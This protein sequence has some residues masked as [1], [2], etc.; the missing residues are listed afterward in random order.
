MFK[1]TLFLFIFGIFFCSFTSSIQ[2]QPKTFDDY[3]KG[4]ASYNLGNYEEALKNFN[5]AIND[6]PDSWASYQQAGYCYFHLNRRKKM[7]ASFNESLK[8]HPDNPELKAFIAG[9]PQTQDLGT[10]PVSS[11]PPPVRHLK[12][13]SSPSIADKVSNEKWGSSSWLNLSGALSYEALGDLSNA[14]NIWNQDITK[15]SAQGNASLANW[16]FQFGVEGGLAL[17]KTNVLSLQSGFET[18]HGFQENLV[19][20]SP[21][22]ENINPQLF[23]AGLNYYR[24]FPSENGRYFVTAGILFGEAIADYY[25]DDPVETLQGPLAGNNFG[26]TIGA[27]REWKMSPTVGFE[28]IGR[29]RY[30]TINQ[31]QN[32]YFVSTGG[33]GQAVLATDSLGNIGLASP[34]SIGQNGLRY[35]TLD[36]TGFNLGF[37]FNFY[38]F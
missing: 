6:D 14:A 33:T 28:L 13:T 34:Q 35:A 7:T 20:S 21:V 36:F 37:A 9:L 25:Q 11:P 38:L 8:L 18:G 3:Q 16:G 32:N 5:A 23:I 22:T 29:F 12:Q 10:T 1:S 27:G 31:L 2:A 19:Y 17:D 26:F 30:L 24:Y 15:A 4:M